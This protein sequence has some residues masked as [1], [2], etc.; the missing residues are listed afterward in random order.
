MRRKKKRI[1][2]FAHF[3]LNNIIDDYVLYYLKSIKEY[4]DF[5]I[6]ISTS[7]LSESETSKVE[8]L[9]D[10]ILIRENVGYD[11]LSW[12]TG[13]EH[14]PDLSDFDELIFCNDSVYGPIFPIKEMFDASLELQSDFWGITDCHAITYHIQSYFIAFNKN[15]FSSEAFRTFMENIRVEKTKRDVINK[16]EVKLTQV[17]LNHGYT[18]KAYVPEMKGMRKLIL[19]RLQQVKNRSLKRLA[20]DIGKKKMMSRK[21]WDTGQLN[22]SHLYWKD[23]VTRFRMP[24]IKVE[25]FRDNPATVDINNYQV[26]FKKHTCYDPALMENHLKR[27]GSANILNA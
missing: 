8:Q 11:F 16:Y 7:S 15:V 22:R 2:L 5:L 4:S 26:F 6:F 24:F 14:T 27:I 17:L 9:C 20:R 19:T 13:L 25:L 23:L 21:R 12:R 1:V 18:G 3:D 10:K